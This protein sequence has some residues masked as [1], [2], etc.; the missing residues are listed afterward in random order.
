M[1]ELRHR[2]LPL[3]IAIDRR[4]LGCAESA[5]HIGLMIALGDIIIRIRHVAA[6]GGVV[7][8]VNMVTRQI[9]PG[10]AVEII[11][12][13][14]D[15][16]AIVLVTAVMVIVIMMMVI[17]VIIPVDAAEERPGGGDAKAVT[18]TFD[19]AIGELLSWRWRQIDRGIGAIRPTAVDG[20]RVIA[21]NVYHL[22]I[23]RFN[24]DDLRRRW[25]WR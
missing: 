5:G 10:N 3:S 4:M 7:L 25:R 23:G 17:I 16:I 2:R 24:F 13:N 20:R 15:V 18:K 12:I 6:I 19:E 9:L 8:P 11:H 21:W 14:I 1:L 22:R